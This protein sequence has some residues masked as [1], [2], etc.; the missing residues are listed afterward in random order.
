L[1]GY[2]HVPLTGESLRLRVFLL[3]AQLARGEALAGSIGKTKRMSCFFARS[4]GPKESKAP[5]SQL[6]S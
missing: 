2:M 3:R 4:G 5:V 1:S 6:V